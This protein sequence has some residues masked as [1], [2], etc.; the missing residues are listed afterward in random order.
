MSAD[1]RA[2]SHLLANKKFILGEE[3]SEN[4]CAVFGMLAQALWGTPGSPYEKLLK[5]QSSSDAVLT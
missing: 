1:L 3:A 2:L 4:D 5:G